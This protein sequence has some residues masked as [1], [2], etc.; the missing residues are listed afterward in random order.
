MRSIVVTTT[1]AT[2]AATYSSVV[3]LDTWTSPFSVSIG[4]VVTGTVDF[5]VQYTY[6]NIQ[7]PGWTAATGVWW[8]LTALKN[9]AATTDSVLSQPASAIRVVQNTGNGSTS[10][11]ILQAGGN[12]VS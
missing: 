2:S 1:D 9:K 5:T 11:T 6:D 7:D 3:A 10:T 8:S 12:G 4:V